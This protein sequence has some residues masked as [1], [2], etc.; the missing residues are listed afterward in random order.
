MV[1]DWLI[2][3]QIPKLLAGCESKTEEKKNRKQNI[4][5]RV[6]RFGW[7]GPSVSNGAISF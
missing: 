1:D 4:K 7:W 2:K 6:W 3:I 5:H